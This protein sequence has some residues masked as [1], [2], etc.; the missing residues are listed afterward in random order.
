MT[1]RMQ[2]VVTDDRIEYDSGGRTL[3]DI[4]ADGEKVVICLDGVVRELDLTAKN[5]AELRAGMKPWLDAGH[6]PGQEPLP[7][8]GPAPEPVRGLKGQGRRREISGTRDFYREL[9]EWAGKQGTEIPTAGRDNKKNYVYSRELIEAYLL[10]LLAVAREGKDGGVATA[11][12]AL[13]RM[14]SLPIPGEQ[15]APAMTGPAGT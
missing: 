6:Q 9:R 15:P 1:T 11:R 12:L 5:A 8:S 2:L 3:T 10:H 14:L 4:G 7:P 13:A